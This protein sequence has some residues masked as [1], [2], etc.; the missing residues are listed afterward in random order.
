MQD[1]NSAWISVWN[2][3]NRFVTKSFRIGI[4]YV[5]GNR[6]NWT[7]LLE[8][9]IIPVKFLWAMW[10]WEKYLCKVL[11]CSAHS[12]CSGLQGAG[13]VAHQ[14]QCG[15]ACS[16][17]ILPPGLLSCCHL[18]CCHTGQVDFSRVEL[19]WIVYGVRKAPMG[20]PRPDGMTLTDKGRMKHKGMT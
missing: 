19:S 12:H 1:Q 5:T 14:L 10:C 8:R 20:P 16:Q 11:E 7:A 18:A 17:A 2:E 15:G 13:L 6:G 4:S 9:R 3:T